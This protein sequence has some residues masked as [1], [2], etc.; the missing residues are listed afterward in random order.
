MRAA[1]YFLAL[2][3]AGFSIALALP[4]LL[5]TMLG[6][7]ERAGRFFIFM[8]LGL[9]V[10]SAM[11]LALRGAETRISRIGGFLLIVSIW[12]MFA[13]F[14]T[15]PLLDMTELTLVQA[16]FEAVSGLTTSGGSVFA[17]KEAVP[18]LILL[19]RSQ[20][21]W[22]G[23]FLTICMILLILAPAGAGGLPERHLTIYNSTSGDRTGQ[24]TRLIVQTAIIYVLTTLVALT[25]LI[26]SGA[27][28]RYALNL[29][30]MSM[31]TGG[32]TIFDEPLDE[33]VGRGGLLVMTVFLFIGAANIFWLGAIRNGRWAQ[34][35][36]F[37]EPYILAGL[38][39]LIALGLGSRLQIVGASQGVFDSIAESVFNGVSLMATSGVESRPG[40]FAL[41]SIPTLL[42]AVLFGGCSFSTAGG[43]KL[44]RLGAMATQSIRE[45]NRLVYPNMVQTRKYGQGE[46]TIGSINAV[47]SYF[48]VAVLTVFLGFLALAFTGLSFENAIVAAVAFFSNAAP[49]YKAA[50]FQTSAAVVEFADFTNA[51]LLIS[52]FIMLLGRLE[53]IV[54][55]GAA[56][57]LIWR[58]R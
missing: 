15:I 34:V 46:L 23:G 37:R 5:G 20:L 56:N 16:I 57:F 21:E 3:M 26:L 14:A 54:L 58:R 25:F 41:L 44:Y 45:L 38:C 17:T 32:F 48:V 33:V 49:F 52:S 4:I 50:A 28:L 19:W 1:L 13:L 27:D 53:V 6:D 24:V 36:S 35:K 31:S 40:V 9:F 22:M 12:C 43:I 39:A 10:S 51:S 29:A 47:W 7:Y 30:L 11:L 18:P 42:F 55:L 2:A 8:A